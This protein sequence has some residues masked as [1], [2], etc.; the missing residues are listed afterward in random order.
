M[1]L[2]AEAIGTF[3]LV[4]AVCGSLLISFA[5]AGGGSGIVGVAL[6]VGLSVTAVTYA[7]GPVSDSDLGG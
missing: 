6:A 3:T 2:S 4:S 5:A 7:V 1:K